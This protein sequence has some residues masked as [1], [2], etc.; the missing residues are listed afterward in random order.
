MKSEMAVA[1][2]FALLTTLCD[3]MPNMANIDY[4]PRLMTQ[5]GGLVVPIPNGVR[6]VIG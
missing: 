4:D 6:K 3:E 5:P 2:R 1:T